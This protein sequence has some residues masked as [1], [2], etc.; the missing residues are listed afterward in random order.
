MLENFKIL[1]S[2]SNPFWASD[3]VSENS[4]SK[5][6]MASW[7]KLKEVLSL[8]YIKLLFDV[9]ALCGQAI[10]QSLYMIH[11]GIFQVEPTCK[12]SVTG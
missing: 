5:F 6:K 2:T 4:I 10:S 8:L 9:R 12:N 1:P 3:P 7:Y 11:S